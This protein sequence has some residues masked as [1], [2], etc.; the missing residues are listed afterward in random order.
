M[1]FIPTV[2]TCFPLDILGEERFPRETMGRN[3]KKDKNDLLQ[4][5]LDLLILRTLQRGKQHGWGISQIIGFP[6][7]RGFE[8]QR[9]FALPGS[10]SAGASGL[11]RVGVGTLGEQPQSEI[12]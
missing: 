11:D 10:S 8:H 1:G 3:T 4:G 9:G 5:T 6:V 2:A 12:L 7:Q